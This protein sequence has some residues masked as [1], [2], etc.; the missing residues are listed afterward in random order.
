MQRCAVLYV[1]VMFMWP[2]GLSLL[3]LSMLMMVGVLVLVMISLDIIFFSYKGE[4]SD[5]SPPSVSR[6]F[7]LKLV[8]VMMVDAFLHT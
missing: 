8:M 1:K 5:R 7:M 4:V 6:K 2:L 3:L